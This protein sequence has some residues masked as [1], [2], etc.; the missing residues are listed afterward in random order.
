MLAYLLLK[1]LVNVG[2]EGISRLVV[3]D[4]R[5]QENFLCEA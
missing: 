4:G 3:L 5:F 1:K 2:E